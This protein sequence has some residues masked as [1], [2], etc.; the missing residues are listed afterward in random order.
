MKKLNALTVVALAAIFVTAPL[1]GLAEEKKAEKAKP[2][3]LEKCIVSDEKLGA[4]ASM[5]PYVFT[6]EGQEIKLCCKSCLKD[7][8]K[9]PKKYAK[10][11]AD[12][13]AA[14]AKAKK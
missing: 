13:E 9:D 11:I 14:K 1:S 2:Y 5:K 10:K 8:N 7:F 6:H 4:D 12:A 3:P